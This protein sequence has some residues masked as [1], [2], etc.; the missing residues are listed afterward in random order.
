MPSPLIALRRLRGENGTVIL[1]GC[2]IPGS[3]GWSKEVIER[4]IKQGFV[5]KPEPVKK[6]KKKAAKKPAKELE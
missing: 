5:S 1:P 3:D 2:P 6:A 4:R